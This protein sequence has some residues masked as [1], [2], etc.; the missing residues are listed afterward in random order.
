MAT[1]IQFKRGTAARWSTVNPVLEFGEHGFVYDTNKIKIGDGVTPWN[2]LPY[3]EGS[4]GIEAVNTYAELPAVGNTSVIYRVI[5]EKT[6]YQ[7]NATTRSY[8]TLTSSS[9]NIEN[10]EII[11][12]GNA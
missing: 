5:D 12:G 3:I 6:L 11:N 2:E 4:T 8:E 10:I 7:Y 1:T 9:S